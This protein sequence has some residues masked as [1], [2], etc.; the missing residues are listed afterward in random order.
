MRP[1]GGLD[2]LAAGKQF[3]EAGPRVRPSTGLRDRALIGVMTYAFACIGAVVA[4]TAIATTTNEISSLPPIIAASTTAPARM[5]IR[6]KRKCT[7]V[8]VA[9]PA[10][11]AFQLKV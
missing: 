10:R 5:P 7:S 6:L 1:A 9:V 4:R 2:N 8:K 11:K 3:V